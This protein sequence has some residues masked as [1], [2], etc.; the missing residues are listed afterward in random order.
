MNRDM[1]R[2]YRS[3]LGAAGKERKGVIRSKCREG[4]L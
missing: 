4:A 1:R 2:V 3:K